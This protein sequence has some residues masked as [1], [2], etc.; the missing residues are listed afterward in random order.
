MKLSLCTWSFSWCVRPNVSCG[1]RLTHVTHIAGNPSLSQ[2][3]LFCSN[4]HPFYTFHSSVHDLLLALYHHPHFIFP[5]KIVRLDS[6]TSAYPSLHLTSTHAWTFSICS[7]CSPINV[8]RKFL[9]IRD[10]TL[11]C[12]IKPFHRFHVCW[13]I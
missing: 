11:S 1:K 7:L 10:I 2:G 8:A 4:V 6:E 5:M 9:S 3:S 12:R 13:L